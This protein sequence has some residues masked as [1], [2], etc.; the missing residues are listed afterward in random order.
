MAETSEFVTIDPEQLQVG[1]YVTLDMKWI[2]HQFLTSSFKIKNE[3]QLADL[4]KLGLKSGC[5]FPSR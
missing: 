4:R 1:L 3:K 2:E 5:A